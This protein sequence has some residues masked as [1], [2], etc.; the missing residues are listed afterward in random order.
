MYEAMYGTEN[1]TQVHKTRNRVEGGAE[2]REAGTEHENEV[3]GL[4]FRSITHG[5]ETVHFWDSGPVRDLPTVV[6]LHGLASTA[7][8]TWGGV[9]GSFRGSYRILAPDLP[10]HGRP[11]RQKFSMKGAAE[12]V[13]SV[14]TVAGVAEYVVVGHSMGGAVAQVLAAEAPSGMAGAVF[15]STACTFT[16][17]NPDKRMQKFTAV[18]ERGIGL[19]PRWVY[20]YFAE[21]LYLSRLPREVGEKERETCANHDWRRIVEALVEV[22]RFDSRKWI[23]HTRLPT[24]VLASAQDTVVPVNRQIHLAETSGAKLVVGDFPHNPMTSDPARAGAE[25]LSAVEHLLG[26]R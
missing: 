15:V 12:Y 5:P 13:K 19:V 14:L 16:D 21:R 3:D 8:H 17:Q 18:A 4:D 25:L 26:G 22:R 1:V 2:G 11:G 6:F 10:G 9:L 7:R 24:L 20:A 23:K